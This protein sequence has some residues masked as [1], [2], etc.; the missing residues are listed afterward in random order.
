MSLQGSVQEVSLGQFWCLHRRQCWEQQG[1]SC[2]AGDKHCNMQTATCVVVHSLASASPD[3][4][5]DALAIQ[6]NKLDPKVDTW[7]TRRWGAG[8]GGGNPNPRK[9]QGLGRAHLGTPVTE[10]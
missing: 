7:S 10:G 6:C 2:R 1:A 3:C 9:H 8:G 4:E 5:L